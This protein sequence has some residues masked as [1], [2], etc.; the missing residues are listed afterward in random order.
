MSDHYV[1][2]KENYVNL[3]DNNVDLSDIKMTSRWQLVALTGSENKILYLATSCEIFLTS[4]HN[5]LTSQHK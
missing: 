4:R 2:L 1:D 3:S 5:D